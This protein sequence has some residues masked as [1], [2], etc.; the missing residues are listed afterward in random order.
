MSII[1][2]AQEKAADLASVENRLKSEIEEII[3]AYRHSWDIYSELL[4]NSVDAINRRYR[5][6]NDPDFYLYES[7]RQKF[8]GLESNSAYVGHIQITINIPERTIEVMD[9]G[10][11]ILSEK[12][13]DFL[14]PKGGDK[15]VTYEYGFKGYGLTFI[16]FI[17]T[18]FRIMSR[19]FLPLDSQAHELHLNGLF[20]WLADENSTVSFPSGPVPDTST[21][22]DLPVDWMEYSS[23]SKTG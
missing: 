18:E 15:P 9:N 22:Q 6:L 3:R 13:E 7:Y 14:L 4:Q 11:G 19:P 8:S 20:D 23:E 2:R 5:I 21:T 17:S 12:L 16:A 10:V 1:Q